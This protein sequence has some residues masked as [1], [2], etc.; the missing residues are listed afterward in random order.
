M[1][2]VILD[3]YGDLRKKIHIVDSTTIQLIA[4]SKQ[5]LEIQYLKPLLMQ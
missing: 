3:C 2:D 1:G 4:K 5:R